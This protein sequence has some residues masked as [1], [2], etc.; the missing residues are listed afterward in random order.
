[1][2]HA[3]IE[4]IQ[5]RVNIAKEDSDFSYFYALLLE[6]EALT[7]LT[8]LAFLA[9][10]VS[11]PDRHR[12]RLEHK[13]LRAD[14]LGPWSAALDDMLIGP[15]S[16]FLLADLNPDRHELAKSFA[17]GSWQFEAVSSLKQCL[18]TLDIEAGEHP[19][20]TTMQRWFTL[21]VNL[22]NKTRGHGATMPGK[23]SK[24]APLLENSL[25]LFRNNHLLFN[26][27][28]H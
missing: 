4:Q 13:V 20:Q 3:A 28:W 6:G 24:A 1:M 21:F 11:D 7:K 27:D 18:D 19:V 15:A 23:V 25:A 22:R 9:S 14:G 12:Y 26:R 2:A 8:V 10:I 5:K 17:S 16:Q